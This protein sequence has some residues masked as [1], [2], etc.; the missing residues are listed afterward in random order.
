MAAAG[1]DQ[2]CRLWSADESIWIQH[3]LGQR[4]DGRGGSLHE[5]FQSR[6]AAGSNQLPHRR[7]VLFQRPHVDKL[8]RSFLPSPL[9]VMIRCGVE[10]V[11]RMNRR[12]A[13]TLQPV[14]VTGIMSRLTSA[15][16]AGFMG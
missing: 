4:P 14:A 1:A 2:R 3:Q 10:P 12:T 11:A 8:A 16:T 15:A 5:S 7:L 9:A 6:L 13:P